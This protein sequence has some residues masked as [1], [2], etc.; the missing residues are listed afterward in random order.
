M[1]RLKTAK[2]DETRTYEIS[3]SEGV[4]DQLEEILKA[5]EYLGKLGA[6]RVLEL[7]I[8]GDGAARIK[9]KR[10]DKKIDLKE[11][12]I[13]TDQDIIKNLGIN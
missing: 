1:K 3:G 13:N 10:T 2:N 6:S 9:V 8:D 11:Q 12:D 4:L 7:G 5:I